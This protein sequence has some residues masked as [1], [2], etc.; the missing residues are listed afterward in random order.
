MLSMLPKLDENYVCNRYT[1]APKSI[2]G[3]VLALVIII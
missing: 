2:G 3:L 1:T